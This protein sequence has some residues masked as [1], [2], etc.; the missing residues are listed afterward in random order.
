MSSGCNKFIKINRAIL[1]ENAADLAY[2]LGWNIKFKSKVK[3]SID[4][5][6]LN[7]KEKILV[8]ILKDSDKT[9]VDRISTA[10]NINHSELSLIL[11][12]MEFRG[13]INALPGNFYRTA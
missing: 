2:Q 3:K 7:D 5:T 13:F 1:V 6:L 12:D 4:V 9:H 10:L 8:E 11:L